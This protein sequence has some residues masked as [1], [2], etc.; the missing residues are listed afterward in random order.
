VPIILL[1]MLVTF[2]LMRGAGGTPF[3]PPEGVTGL[4]APLQE[5]LSVFYR[6]EEP[7]PVEFAV[8]VRNVF[9]LQFGP[10]LVDRRRSV[11]DVVE[12]GFPVTGELVL[13]AL[14]WALPLGLVLGLYAAVRRG[15]VL[16]HLATSVSTVLL[17]VPVFFV[18]FVLSQYLVLRWGIFPAG[19]DGWQTKVLPAFALGLAPA[20]YT[21]R[22]V[23]AAAVETLQADYVRTARA[24]GLRSSHVVRTHVLRNSL[25][26]LLSAAAPMI[27]LL[28]TGALF[29]EEAF[30]IPGVSSSFLGA[31]RSRDYPMILGLTVALTVVVIG[32]NLLADVVMAVLDPRLREEAS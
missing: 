17:V 4:P 19:W 3:R 15:S 8:Y 25:V 1:V 18:T 22:L 31:A 30:G 20:G 32:L 2:A 21:A 24:K 16:D 27:A 7:W 13:L 6:L 9:T 29:V 28:V 5:E 10:S 26:P 23:R 12:Q 14:V 11:D